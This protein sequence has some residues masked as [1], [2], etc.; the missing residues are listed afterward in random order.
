MG[1]KVLYALFIEVGCQIDVSHFSTL[2]FNSLLLWNFLLARNLFRCE[3]RCK[4]ARGVIH[5]FLFE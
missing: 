3:N 2:S 4:S 5:Q 1:R